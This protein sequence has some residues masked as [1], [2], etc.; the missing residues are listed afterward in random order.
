MNRRFVFAAMLLVTLSL[1]GVAAGCG[2]LDPNESCLPRGKSCGT[3]MSSCCDDMHCV[4]DWTAMSG[5][6]C[7]L[8]WR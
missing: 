2:I 4:S 1:S 5:K 7:K 6:M 8:D 3:G